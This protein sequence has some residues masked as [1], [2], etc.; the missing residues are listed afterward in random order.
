V[1][2]YIG[3]NSGWFC[4]SRGGEEEEKWNGGRTINLL[5]IAPMRIL[6]LKFLAPYKQFE[7]GQEIKFAQN[8]EIIAGPT[9]TFLN[10]TT[11]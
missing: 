9:Y 3:F 1:C 5:K 7:E 2:F 6:K 10:M 8:D 11:N 4:P